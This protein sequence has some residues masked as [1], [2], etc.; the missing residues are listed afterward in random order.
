[1]LIAIFAL[2]GTTVS[3][4]PG[5][6][7][8]YDSTLESIWAAV[9][10]APMAIRRYRPV[11]SALLFVAMVMIQLIFG[12]SL[13]V[14]DV[15]APVLLY[16]V[17]VYADYAYSKAFII[18]AFA[19]GIAADAVI[20][21]A[22]EVGPIMVRP[23]SSTYRESCAVVYTRGLDATCAHEL[24][25]NFL[26]LGVAIACCLI[27][28]IVI[29]YWQRARLYTINILQERNA[30]LAEREEDAR[31]NAA[32]AERA[33]IARDM[34]DVVAHS[35]SIIIVQADGGRYAGAHDP[36][37]AR[38]TMQT[39]RRESRHALADMRRLLGVLTH[40]E[41]YD[42]ADIDKLITQ[43]NAASASTTI[44]RIISGN[45][46][47][48][49][50]STAAT[51]ALYRA[52]Q[53]A[54]TNIRK[55]AGSHVLVR[56]RE[57]WSP[58]GVS[59]SISDDG[60]GAGSVS[61]QH[62]PGYGLIGMRQR[63]EAVNGTLTAGP[64]ESG[65][66]HVIVRIPRDAT[67]GIPASTEREPAAP[68]PLSRII[69]GT[70]TFGSPRF[71][72]AP[73]IAS[74]VRRARTALRSLRRRRKSE[75]TDD[76]THFN[77]IERLS[78][79]S[80]KHYFAMDVV[81]T[82]MVL[83][84]LLSNDASSSSIM[85]LNGMTNITVNKVFTA[86]V[87][88][89]LTCRRRLPEFSAGCVAIV[90]AIQLVFSPSLLFAD[91]FA[92]TALYSA[93]IYGRD[94]AWRWAGMAALANCL[95]FECK[96]TASALNYPTLYAATMD[97]RHIARNLPGLDRA[98]FS[99]LSGGITLAIVCLGIIAMARWSRS[100]GANALVLQAREEAIR[101]EQEQQKIFAANMERNRISSSIQAEVTETLTSVIATADDGLS[102]FDSCEARGDEPSPETI[103]RAFETIGHQGRVALAHMRD[104]LRVLHDTGFSTDQS[105]HGKEAANL[106]PAAPLED[107]IQGMPRTSGEA[108][109]TT[110][111]ADTTD[112]AD[113]AR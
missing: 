92:L 45:P 62:V 41:H 59:V 95:L 51:I 111:A 54:L 87:L 57:A 67:A 23:H 90:C 108:T 106:R 77:W 75:R 94:H 20:T 60:K 52:V 110:E 13:A 38:E 17:I 32:L 35:L 24:A 72:G 26:G 64:G 81:G 105:G 29:A 42:Y 34:H 99:G 61:S 48:D 65:G 49:S 83:T 14:G 7:Y 80:Q 16:S 88:I 40:P 27:S 2:V 19:M 55:Y 82:S 69:A 21:W 18:L 31:T 107:Q 50:L 1:M 15:F 8:Q 56:I 93:V 78:Q 73:S 112:M 79:W 10:I 68:G 91:V 22:T 58:A 98:V 89:P 74:T 36:S 71:P 3:T 44:T 39:I 46:D 28:G 113:T 84:L 76:G 37:L 47:P 101:A 86:L 104:L 4:T 63:L 43:A 30:A 9:L 103:S 6:L 11:L 33:R 70:F 25:G 85:D 66:F 100:Q 12:P 109:D 53:E 97:Y 102:A 96:I 5:L